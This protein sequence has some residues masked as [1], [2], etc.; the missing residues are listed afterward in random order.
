METASHLLA[1]RE[2]R[3]YVVRVWQSGGFMA[4]LRRVDEETAVLFKDVAS[5]SRYLE[6]E[7]AATRCVD[8]SHLP[9]MKGHP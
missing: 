1:A 8:P 4:S 9:G 6:A 5:L 3:T 2:A 7:A